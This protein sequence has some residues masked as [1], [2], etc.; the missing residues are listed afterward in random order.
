VRPSAGLRAAR[1]PGAIGGPARGTG[2][3]ER[4]KWIVH[5]PSK[6]VPGALPPLL[7]S[8]SVSPQRLEVTA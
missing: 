7:G 5:P 8:G 6:P 4:E 2:A 1:G 3:S